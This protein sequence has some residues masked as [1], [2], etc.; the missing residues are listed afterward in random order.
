MVSSLSGLLEPE[1][2]EYALDLDP[3]RDSVELLL[4]LLG[5]ESW[6]V[7]KAAEQ[8]IADF[9]RHEGLV[10]GL[11]RGL[12]SRENAGLRNSS[13][14]AI[15]LLGQAAVEELGK[16]LSVEDRDLRKFVIEALGM[17]GSD[18]AKKLVLVALDDADINVAASAAEAL[19]ALGGDG[20]AAELAGRLRGS[21]RQMQAYLLDAL[22]RM[23]AGLT[24][25]EVSDL[26]GEAVLARSLYPLLGASG[27]LNALPTL[28]EGIKHRS[29][30]NRDAA[31]K[32][33][34][35]F[36]VGQPAAGKIGD[37]IRSDELLRSAVL[38]ALETEDESA[39]GA[40]LIILGTSNEV[41]LAPLLLDSCATRTV[42]GIGVSVVLSWGDGVVGPLLRDFFKVGVETRVLFL[43][44]IEQVGGAAVIDDLI[45]I[46]TVPETRCAEAAVRIIGRFGNS[47]VIPQLMEMAIGASAEQERHIGNALSAIAIRHRAEATKAILGALSTGKVRP[48]WLVVLAAL[49][50]TELTKYVSL[51]TRDSDSLVRCTAYECAGAFGADF[52]VGTLKMGLAD[53]SPRVR[54]AAARTLGGLRNYEAVDALLTATRDPDTSVVAAALQSLGTLGGPKVISTLRDAAGSP[55]APVAIAALQSLFLLNAPDL[56]SAV[57]RASRHADPEVVCESI[58][59][60][61]RLPSEVAQGLLVELLKH[62]HWTVRRAAAE[63]L[64]R[65]G[66]AVDEQQLARV[67]SNESD[68][69]VLDA[70]KD[71]SSAVEGER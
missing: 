27:D 64:V 10:E 56:A 4:A 12:A 62:W 45:E 23:G 66:I 36:A 51:A 19:G 43:E 29:E 20:I 3:A 69:L 44:V 39:L 49:G 65:R 48:A 6:R 22:A 34:S 28:V 18:E 15:G 58:D 14:A 5:D 33:L 38:G 16:L 32:A 35:E 37:L 24:F 17:V 2:H 50:D 61:I 70:L 68:P 42:V 47:S 25:A 9:S 13:A 21:G 40:A 55:K 11:L 7:R 41:E 57:E 46:A 63:C 1:R 52:P 67:A 59:A 8:R 53:E 30:G 26:V 54:L 31:L 71:V 60:S